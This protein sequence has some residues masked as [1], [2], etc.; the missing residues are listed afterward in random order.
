MKPLIPIKHPLHDNVLFGTAP[1]HQNRMQRESRSVYI[2][3]SGLKLLKAL[4]LIAAA[5]WMGGAFALM[6][7][8]A[9][10]EVHL[11]ERPA[12]ALINLC[13]YYVDVSVVV[14]GIVGCILTGLIYSAY[15]NFG[16]FKF[17]WI[18]YKWFITC[19]AFFWGT[20]FLG[21]WSDD[22]FELSVEWGMYDILNLIHNCVMPQTSWGALAQFVM[23]SSVA[24]ISVYRPVSMS[25]WYDH[26][27]NQP[28][29]VRHGR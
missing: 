8:A 16:F 15:T 27:K 14:P 18:I 29:G 26:Q 24:V 23:L 25:N 21:P 28:T 1:T 9:L 17:F 3:D 20:T 5:T 2:E 19:N 10:R 12:A 7:L 4:H 22:L 13:I 6:A 11:D